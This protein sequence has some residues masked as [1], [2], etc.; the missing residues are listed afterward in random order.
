MKI[1]ITKVIT[2]AIIGAVLTVQAQ[3]FTVP[4]IVNPIMIGTCTGSACGSGGASGAA[5]AG[6]LTGTTLASN[7]TASSLLS[8][9]SGTFGTAAFTNSSAYAAS[10]VTSGA[11]TVGRTISGT[12]DTLTLSDAGTRLVTTS[13]SAV[14]ITVPVNTSVDWTT[15][16]ATKVPK[17]QFNIVGAGLPTI[18]GAS[19]V[20]VSGTVTGVATG[21]LMELTWLAN[22]TWRVDVT[23]ASGGGSGTSTYGVTDQAVSL[24]GETLHTTNADASAWHEGFMASAVGPVATLINSTVAGD[25]PH[26][27]R[28]HNVSISASGVISTPD[29]ATSTSYCEFETDAGW[30]LGYAAPASSVAVFNTTPTLADN[31]ITGQRRVP[32]T[33]AFVDFSTS[34]TVA[35]GV[36]LIINTNAGSTYSRTLTLCANPYDGQR[37]RIFNPLAGDMQGETIAG[38]GKTVVG[39]TLVML[40]RSGGSVTYQYNASNTTWYALDYNYNFTNDTGGGY[41]GVNTG[42]N[43]ATFHWMFPN[44]NGDYTIGGGKNIIQSTANGLSGRHSAVG[45]VAS[46]TLSVT[47]T[48]SGNGNA[49]GA[50]VQG[51]VYNSS[52]PFGAGATNDKEVD[53]KIEGTGR[54]YVAGYKWTN[55]PAG[56]GIW[57][58]SKN[59]PMYFGDTDKGQYATFDLSGNWILSHASGNSS[60]SR[61]TAT[62]GTITIPNNI[63]TEILAGSGTITLE[64]PATPVDGQYIEI[65]LETVYAAITVQATGKT[66]IQGVP[67]TVTAGS[68]AKYKYNLAR[69]TWYR[70]D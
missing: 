19:G 27:Y 12:T 25:W 21:N 54:A 69:T 36:T 53:W 43:G 35:D 61:S 16:S 17:V 8:A 10:S 46:D 38:N 67:L 66:F 49:G 50:Y 28:C 68:F 59:A 15:L 56:E 1:S 22:N 2:I 70:V 55:S 29:D 4:V 6:T 13:A 14:M 40:R 58:T 52:I 41:A 42:S 60:E 30:S 23:G 37:L 65:T 33:V 62:T 18:V 57:Y 26:K 24:T 11:L 7:V 48:T 32:D 45:F 51:Q 63:G 20:S 39:P 3:T 44:A 64:L 47:D 9:A 5:A 31:L 34:S